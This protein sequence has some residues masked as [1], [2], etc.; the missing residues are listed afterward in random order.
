MCR[1]NSTHGLPVKHGRIIL[2][3]F[4]T[5]DPLDNKIYT[6]FSRSSNKESAFVCFSEQAIFLYLFVLNMFV[7][8]SLS[9]VLCNL[10]TSFE[11]TL[12]N[13]GL[14]PTVLYCVKNLAIKSQD[15]KFYIIQRKKYTC[16]SC[17]KIF[18]Q[19]FYSS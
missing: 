8:E 2:P 6:S 9:E 10:S 11:S 19:L 16:C 12:F 13:F 15:L 17:I 5:T 3:V 18:R 1:S 4:M 14:V 7:S